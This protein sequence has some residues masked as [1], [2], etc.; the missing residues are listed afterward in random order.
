[1]D[2]KMASFMVHHHDRQI[3]YHQIKSSKEMYRPSQT[4]ASDSKLAMWDEPDVV[5]KKSHA[6]KSYHSKL[7]MWDEPDVVLNFPLIGTTPSLTLARS[8]LCYTP[9]DSSQ[10]Q[11]APTYA[12]PLMILHKVR[13][14]RLMLHPS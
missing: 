9:H 13:A 7:A 3:P 12:T 14:L 1:M 8:D 2:R 10:S 11:S 4:A 6:A 5:L